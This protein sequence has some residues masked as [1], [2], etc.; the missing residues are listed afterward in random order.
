MLCNLNSFY[1]FCGKDTTFLVNNTITQQKIGMKQYIDLQILCHDDEAT[2]IVTAFLSDH[3]FDTFDSET[4]QQ[5]ILLHAFITAECWAECCDMAREAIGDFGTIVQEKE[6]EDENW[7]AKWEEESFQA[8]DI[9]GIIRIRAPHH[10]APASGVIDIVVR[11]Q[12][13]FGSGHHH[14]TRLMCKH[15]SNIQCAGRVL[16]VGCGT[17]VLAITALKCGATSADAIDIDPWSTT[18]AEEAATL[19]D[20]AEKIEVILGTVEAI[21]GRTYDMVMANIN[22][23]IILN[24]IDRYAKALN[25]G[26]TLL[27]S[28]F[29]TEDLE[30]ITEATTA[31]GLRATTTLEENG[32]IAAAFE[33]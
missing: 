24:D 19:N 3:P 33:K 18:S 13:S 11:P 7:N 5:G 28:G 22:R 2:E 30:A 26:G 6:I 29:L 15:I 12:M 1:Y 17:G 25:N 9:D 14:T 32:W 16:D 10:E 8:V 23:N 27:L 20:V 31:H 21:E 4:H